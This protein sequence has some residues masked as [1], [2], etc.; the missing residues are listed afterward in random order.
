MIIIT[1]S[2]ESLGPFQLGPRLQDGHVLEGIFHI[3]S[4]EV[5]GAWVRL[6]LRKQ[7]VVQEIVRENWEGSVTLQMAH[8]L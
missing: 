2:P 5:T 4:L 3:S 1:F 6:H 7:G 8:Q